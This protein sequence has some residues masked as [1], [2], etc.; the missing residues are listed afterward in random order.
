[1]RKKSFNEY[2]EFA[3]DAAILIGL[4]LCEVIVFL[5]IRWL[6]GMQT[7]G[8]LL[9]IGGVIYYTP[10]AVGNISAKV[11]NAYEAE[12]SITE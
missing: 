10:M 12:R 4:V 3:A 11:M 8:I 1:M 5:A 9:I 2:L 6:R 7:L